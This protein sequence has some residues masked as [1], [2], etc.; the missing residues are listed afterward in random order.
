[1]SVAQSRRIEAELARAREEWAERG[2]VVVDTG[3]TYIEAE[4]VR[5]RVRKRSHRYDLDD[6]GTAT[7]LA[8]KPHRWH[9]VADRVVA[10]EGFNVNRRGIVFVQAVEGRYLAALAL[11]LADSS[12]AVFAALLD[13]S[14]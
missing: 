8:G 6:G 2:E 10:E 14:D 4:P 1:V 12:V 5:I 3:L 9:E 13:L 7:R 11:R